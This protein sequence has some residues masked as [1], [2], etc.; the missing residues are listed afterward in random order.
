M[1][2]GFASRGVVGVENGVPAAKRVRRSLGCLWI[3]GPG[4]A[5]SQDAAPKTRLMDYFYPPNRLA[6]WVY[7]TPKE[8]GGQKASRVKVVDPSKQLTMYANR[9]GQIVSYNKRVMWISTATGKYSDGTVSF[10]H[11]TVETNE[12]YGAASNYAIYGIDDFKNQ[13]YARFSPGAVFP[14]R[15]KKGQTVSVNTGMFN[16]GGLIGPDANLSLQLIGRESLTVPAGIFKDCIHL[17]FSFGIK[18]G[19]TQEAEEWWAKGVGLIQTKSRKAKG[20]FTT[21]KLFSYEIPFE[22]TVEFYKARSDFGTTR[23]SSG[24]WVEPGITKIF[25]VRNEGNKVVHGMKISIVGSSVFTCLDPVVVPLAPGE[26]G[27]FRVHFNPDGA[28]KFNARIK[29]E[30]IG[31]PENCCYKFITG[32]GY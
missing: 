30:Q 28:G 5:F 17:R 4:L 2:I 32:T 8:G 24:Q 19:P 21:S 16:S 18:G 22:P 20:G 7:L 27:E 13:I 26:I 9:G 15:F 23:A 29:A 10:N 6:E 14:E 11:S 25:R 1:K 31:N 12:F 3:L